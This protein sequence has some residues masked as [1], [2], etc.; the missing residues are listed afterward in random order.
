[1]SECIENGIM[2]I[3]RKLNLYKLLFNSKNN[4]EDMYVYMCMRAS[5]GT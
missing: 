5:V 3:N 4:I 2:Y 1:M